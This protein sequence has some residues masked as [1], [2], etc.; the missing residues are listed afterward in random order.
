MIKWWFCGSRQDDVMSVLNR[1]KSNSIYGV[2]L[3]ILALILLYL[4]VRPGVSR[5]ND[6]IGEATILFAAD[7]PWIAVADECVQ[8]SWK[9]FGIR[10]VSLNDNSVADEGQAQQCSVLN[11]DIRLTVKFMDGSTKTYRLNL[12]FI[13]VLVKWLSFYATNRFEPFRRW[14]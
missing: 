9:V 14:Q 10:E 7:R 13:R 11:K 6:H 2:G 12:D 3:S 1:L 8:L 5:I 4:G